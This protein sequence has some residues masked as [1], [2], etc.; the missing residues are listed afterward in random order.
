MSRAFVKES[1]ESAQPPERMIEDGP[2]PVTPEGLRQIDDHVSRLEVAMKL[3][4]N[5]LLRETMARD[6]RYWTIRKSSAE[7]VQPSHDGTVGFGSS[8]TI[9]RNGKTQTFR[10]VGVDEAD[11]AKGLISFRSPLASAL[12]GARVGEV[13]EAA[14]PL[15]EITIAAIGTESQR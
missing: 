2:N 13:I 8:V 10:I 15:G 6:L 1:A 4:A 12:L 9:T 5:I 11:A 14:E 7:L 3:E